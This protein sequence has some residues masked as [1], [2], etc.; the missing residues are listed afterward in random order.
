[1]DK[2]IRVEGGTSAIARAALLTVGAMTLL[3]I[4]VSSHADECIGDLGWIRV[5]TDGPEPRH[6]TAVAYDSRRRVTVLFGGE[7]DALY[8]DTWEWDGES[9]TRH[10]TKV[11]PPARRFH[12]LAYDSRRGVTVLF[13]GSGGG[14]PIYHDTWEWNGKVWVRR[15][16]E[17]PPTVRAHHA[18]A[19]DEDRAV[20]VLF[21]GAG[22]PDPHGMNDT[23]EWDGDSWTRK[24]DEQPCKPPPARNTP[25]MDYDPRRGGC[26]LFGGHQNTEH[27]RAY[28]DT[29]K[30]NGTSWGEICVETCGVSGRVGVAGA[31]VFDS[32][33]GVTTLFGGYDSDVGPMDDTWELASDSPEWSEVPFRGPPALYNHTMAYDRQRKVTV[34]FGGLGREINGD[35]WEFSVNDCNE[36]TVRDDCDIRN[37]TSADLNDNG[38]PDECEGCTVTH[39]VKFKRGIQGLVSK[40][41]VFREGQPV[42]RDWRVCVDMVNVAVP[43]DKCQACA[44]TRRSGRAAIKCQGL[45]CGATYEAC[46]VSVEDP[47]GNACPLPDPACQRRIVGCEP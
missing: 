16:E 2:M 25:A 28:D 11:R 1:M 36:N 17:C 13:G 24:C 4:G 10:E 46:V 27:P 45:T 32:Y 34:L 33:R 7:G 19:Y 6:G 15:C 41:R 42:E 3:S 29:W 21:G 20:V 14:E 31:M 9:W 38:I 30:W 37:G 22:D 43:E 35:T 40:L 26:V 39:R 5:A 18:M 47:E 44:A 23:W 12:R 8:D